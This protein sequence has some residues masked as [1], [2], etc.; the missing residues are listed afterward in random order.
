M[1]PIAEPSLY[2]R[3]ALAGKLT[4][5]IIGRGGVTGWDREQDWDIK[6]AKGKQGATMTD[7]GSAPTS[8]AI[9]IQLWRTG[10]SPDFVHDFDDWE[11]DYRPMLETARVKGEALVVGH[12]II[13]GAGVTSV[14]VK[15]IGPLTDKGRGLW[16]VKV[17]LLEFLKPKA[18]GGTPSAAKPG[19]W[20]GGGSAS[21][22]E[23]SAQDEQDKEIEKL[24]EEAKKA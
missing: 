6:K 20:T 16:T 1:N 11:N 19:G 7:Q 14:V 17:E 2:E 23:P 8:G 12:P 9:E 24:I 15:K 21:K 3:A 13:N 18:A 5:G 10:E 4:P 22:G